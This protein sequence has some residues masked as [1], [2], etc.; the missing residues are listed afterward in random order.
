M[1]GRIVTEVIVTL[2]DRDPTSVRFAGENWE[3]R[4]A[5]IDLLLANTK[6]SVA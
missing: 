4:S 5:L 6:T 1:G 2:L 3:P